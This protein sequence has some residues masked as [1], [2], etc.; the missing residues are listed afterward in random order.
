M[1]LAPQIKLKQ[2][3]QLAM[4]PQLQQAIKLLTLTN[5]ELAAFVEE[6]LE[7]NP[8]LERGTGT[9][10][11]REDRIEAKQESDSGLS[12]LDLNAPSAAASDAMDATE[13][14][15]NAD[16]T[17]ADIAAD[18]SLGAA[19]VGGD[20][21]WSK[22]GSGG[23]FFGN[24]DY[25]PAAN[26][27]Y[28]ITLNE[29]L[30]AQLVMAIHDE[31]DRMIGAYLIDQVDENGYLRTDLIELADRLGVD[32]NRVKSVLTILQTFEPTG[33]MA[34]S[35]SECMALQLKERGELDAPMQHLLDNLEMLAKHDLQA[36]AKICGLSVAKLGEY[37]ERLRSL[38]PKP[39]LA[40]G[41]DMAGVVEPD[42]F[43]HERPDG[44]WAVEL[45]SDTLPRV[46]VN[47]RYYAEVCDSTKDE[48][49]KS[50]MSECSQNASW[51][52][53]SLDQRARTILKVSSEI[54]KFQDGFF[55]YGIDHLRPLNLKTV[56]DAIDMH[57]STVSRVTSNKYI[58]TTRGTFELK[59]FFTAAIASMDGGVAHSSEAV[60]HKIK[61]LIDEE[62]GVK[63]VLSDDKLVK[64]LQ[65]H[66]IDIARRTVAKYRESLGIPSSVQRRRIINNKQ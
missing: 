48:K 25:D 59:Y 49:V 19:S 17:A 10:N 16:A 11:R 14:Q 64:L 1:A 62:R 54:V 36:L 39:G 42:V 2:G 27:A 47:S 61:I 66:G 35:L 24:N 9:E 55:A 5:I 51:L 7:S 40:Y 28:E 32:L 15:L 31:R 33:V 53:K 41:S 46:L 56:A 21:D 3:Q 52:V 20:V 63:S 37:A 13:S 26:T 29:H 57:E 34:R 18:N 8:L 43:V 38:A 65:N 58:A 60:R 6:Q 45:N 12:E 22:A 50:Y 44:G 23:S 30:T 4:T